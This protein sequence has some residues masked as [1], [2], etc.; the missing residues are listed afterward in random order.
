MYKEGLASHSNRV[1]VNARTDTRRRA[2]KGKFDTL[3][4]KKQVLDLTDQT[5]ET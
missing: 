1:G 4:Q 3:G 2:Q 5:L